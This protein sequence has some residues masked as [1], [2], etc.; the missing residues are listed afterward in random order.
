MTVRRVISIWA[1]CLGVLLLALAAWAS[2]LDL[3]AWLPAVVGVVLITGG[4]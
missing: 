1:I 3:S 4:S 2:Y